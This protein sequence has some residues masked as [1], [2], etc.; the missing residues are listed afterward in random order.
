MLTK[1]LQSDVITFLRFP[2]IVGVV[3][4]HNAQSI[5]G[6]SDFGTEYV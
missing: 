6:I 3:L 5:T 2:L 1:D 4:V